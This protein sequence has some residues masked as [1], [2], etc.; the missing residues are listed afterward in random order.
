MAAAAV[1]EASEADGSSAA[2]FSELRGRGAGVATA[3]FA[4]PTSTGSSS[5]LGPA[6]FGLLDCQVVHARAWGSLDGEACNPTR[7]S[8]AEGSTEVYRLG[9]RPPRSRGSDLDIDGNCLGPEDLVVTVESVNASL[10]Q[11]LC[12]GIVSGQT[13][14]TFRA[15]Y[16]SSS[17]KHNLRV[18]APPAEYP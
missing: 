2:S 8:V 1:E 6:S 16:R 7:M 5:D 10:Q 18:R 13:E 9:T 14:E 15:L 4:A 12:G 3:T 17:K 11:Q